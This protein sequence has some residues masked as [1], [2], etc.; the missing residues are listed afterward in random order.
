M[1][2]VIPC[3]NC[4]EFIAECLASL[5]AQTF[6]NWT[7]LVADDASEDGTEDRV[8]PFLDDPRIRYRRAPERLWL[9]GNTLHALRSLTPGFS[10]V[11]AILDG[12]DWVMPTCLEKLW[13]EHCRGYDL[14]YTDEII[15]GQDWSPG[16]ALVPGLPVRRQL[17]SFSQLRSFK[18][19]LFDLLPDET[20]RDVQGRYFRAA[21]DLALYFPMAELAGPGKV[22]FIPEKLYHYRVHEQCNFKVLRQEQLGNN[23]DIRSRPPL[24][25][26]TKFFDHVVTV[27]ELEKSAIPEFAAEVRRQYPR[28]HTVR[29]DHLIS[30]DQWD[31]WRAYHNLW[32]GEGVFLAT[33]EKENH[34]RLSSNHSDQRPAQ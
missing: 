6:Q 18:S 20:F 17:W 21:G 33:A 25:P 24:E 16:G 5:V 32:V 2:I 3:R 11:V 31:S 4:A 9:L 13:A 34:D 27:E 14:V 15:E 10:D 7:A 29:I 28:P 23:W 8:K 30:P 26:Q 19:Y 1:H 12:D 22:R